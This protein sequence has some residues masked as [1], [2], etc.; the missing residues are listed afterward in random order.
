MQIKARVEKY[1]N[2]EFAKDGEYN[3]VEVYVEEFD[4]NQQL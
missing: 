4:N 1:C 3:C 2:R